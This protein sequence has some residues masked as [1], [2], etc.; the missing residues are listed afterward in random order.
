MNAVAQL[1]PLRR[2]VSTSLTSRARKGLDLDSQPP[3]IF[4]AASC[5]PGK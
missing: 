1:H 2:G 5:D 3:G 4:E